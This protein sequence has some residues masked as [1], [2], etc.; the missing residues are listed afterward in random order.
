MLVV[1]QL[2]LVD[3]L[4]V[5]I[6]E[7]LE[8]WNYTVKYRLPSAIVIGLILNIWDLISRHGFQ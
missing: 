6:T 7:L 1:W 3:L 8:N 5:K 2:N 4:I